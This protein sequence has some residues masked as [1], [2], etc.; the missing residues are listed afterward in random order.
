M[1]NIRGKE[2]KDPHPKRSF[3][4]EEET[5]KFFVSMKPRE[6]SWSLFFKELTEIIKY[7]KKL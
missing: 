3:R 5:Y 6:K 7:F 1:A 4:M 2:K